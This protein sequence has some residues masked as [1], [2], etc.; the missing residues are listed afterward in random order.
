MCWECERS[1]GSS[2]KTVG[3][4]LFQLEVNGIPVQARGANVVPPDFH[5]NQDATLW[6]T[7]VRHARNA[8]MNMVRVWGGGVYP[9]DAFFEACDEQGLLVWQD[10]MFACAMVPDDDGFT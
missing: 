5:S 9:P 1:N 3:E 2:K 4:R 6:K 7:L 10:F 8:N